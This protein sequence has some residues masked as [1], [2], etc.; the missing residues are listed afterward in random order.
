V[1][2]DARI[3]GGGAR[4]VPSPTSV[5]PH[6]DVV[7]VGGGSA[8]WVAAVAAARA[9]ASVWLVERYGF[10]GGTAA[11][12]ML[13]GIG[14]L[15]NPAN[16]QVVFGIA[17]EVFARLTELGGALGVVP[18]PLQTLG[19]TITP[20]DKEL[21]KYLAQTMVEE[22]GARILLHSYLVDVVREHGLVEAISVVNKSGTQVVPGSVFID[23]TGDADLVA[24]AGGEFVKGEGDAPLLQPTTLMFKLGNVDTD[25]ILDH[26]RRH[27]DDFAERLSHGGITPEQLTMPVGISGFTSTVREAV[28]AGE[29]APNMDS[30]TVHFTLRRGEVIMNML[31]SLRVD[32]T[33]VLDLTRAELEGRR[34]V[35]AALG[36]LRKRVPGFAHAHLIETGV[37]VGVRETRRIVG[38]YVLTRTDVLEG[39]RFPDDVVRAQGGISYHD[40]RGRYQ[41]KMTKP[42]RP[43][44]IPFR[45]LQPRGLTNV[46]VAGRC[47]SADRFAFAGVRSAGIA[48]ATGQAAG[49]AAALAAR[50][51]IPIRSID[52]GELQA[53]LAT[54]GVRL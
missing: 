19:V 49:V 16:E 40:P 41:T 31:H 47:L 29:Y 27:P 5:L 15:F 4:A 11:G 8:G 33:D 54:Q 20:Y 46:L 28:E 17:D 2:A 22:A 1:S 18:R 43:Y 23:A 38:E 32:A 24:L 39:R 53:C 30:I 12:V 51:R 36:V 21:L 37:Q 50:D 10:L 34:Q 45:A 52:I 9:G 35:V 7:V 42:G 25:A 13:G 44:G 48:M 26:V 3:A 14:G 6:A